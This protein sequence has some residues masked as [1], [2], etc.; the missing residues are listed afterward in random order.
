MKIINPASLII[1]DITINGVSWFH[2]DCSG[3]YCSYCPKATY[4]SSIGKYYDDNGE[5]IDEVF[6]L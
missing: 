5:I 4:D 6:N 2:S 1:K 3:G